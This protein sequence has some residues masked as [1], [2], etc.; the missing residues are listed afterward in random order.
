M[1]PAT[2]SSTTPRNPC[3]ILLLLASLLFVI[4]AVAYAILPV[5]EEHAADAGRPLPPSPFRT[6]LRRDGW[7]WLLVELAALTVF[8]LLSMA[9]DRLRTLQKKAA[10]DTIPASRND[11]PPT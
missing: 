10:E 4:T 1:T 3:Y 9:L 2:M 8:G 6:A 11:L 7:V 5:L